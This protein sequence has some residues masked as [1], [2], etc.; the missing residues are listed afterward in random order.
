MGVVSRE[1][2]DW[3]LAEVVRQQAPRHYMWGMVDAWV[4]ATDMAPNGV[5]SYHLLQ[6]SMRVR[7]FT[8]Q[9]TWRR[10]PVSFRDGGSATAW[11]HIPRQVGL[12]T[13]A[14]ADG[15][16]SEDEA[17]EY[18]KRFLDIHPFEDGN[19][20]VG[21]VLYNLLMGTLEHPQMMPY[22]YGQEGH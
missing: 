11:E 4:Y 16:Q 1:V 17:N 21:S 19:G 5:T 3:A 20:R 18:V 13:D 9:P 10:T 2:K 15:C 7:L 14:M 12:L 6:L 8:E 22:Y